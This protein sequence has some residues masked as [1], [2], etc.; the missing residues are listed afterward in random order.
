MITVFTPSYNRAKL[1]PALYESLKR[2]TYKD[3]EWLVVDD[4]STDDT[5][6][7]VE[8]FLKEKAISVRY[9]YKENGGKHTAINLGV[10]EA[11]GELFFIVD[12]DDELPADSLHIINTYYQEIAD[13]D[14]IVGVGGLISHRDGSMVT[15]GMDKTVDAS[16][17]EMKYRIKAK[18]DFSE[19]YKT[20]MLRQ[21]PF[22]EI[23]GERFCPEIL[24]W[25]RLTQKRK[26]RFFPKVIY[27]RDY[28]DGGLSDTIV[29]IRMNSPLL[30]MMTYQEL[31]QAPI[32]TVYKLRNAINYWRFR[33]CLAAQHPS[34]SALAMPRLKGWLNVVRPLGWL[35]HKRDMKLIRNSQS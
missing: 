7:V 10:R 34:V 20:A 29:R 6:Q 19:A 22:P 28:L 30:S 1:L 4:G 21:C 5:R 31:T 32:Q 26:V 13:D 3:F 16:T 2:Q 17:M 15:K 33:C 9:F 35:M 27:Y 11:R 14:R 25:N 12:S 8:G 24:V 18:G 23:P